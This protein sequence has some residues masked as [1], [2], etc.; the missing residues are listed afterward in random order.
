[1]KSLRL[2]YSAAILLSVLIMSGCGG[3]DPEPASIVGKWQVT[4]SE[5][6]ITPSTQ[7]LVTFLVNQGLSQSDAQELVDEML[8][9]GGGST[10][11]TIDIK[12]DGTYEEVDG[13]DTYAGKWELSA[14][15]KT[16]T[17]D[18]GTPA[19]TVATVAKLDGSSLELD[20]DY[21]GDL[22]FPTSS[23]LG[24]H[25]VITFKKV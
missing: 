14:D 16:L 13:T 23:G 24:Y 17:I 4:K 8:D 20:F 22:N 11:G 25:V 12:S 18:K 3:D 2:V 15:G 21:S 1:M 7:A 19:Q 5:P 9:A 6:K 10:S